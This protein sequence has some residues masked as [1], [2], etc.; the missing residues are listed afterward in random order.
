MNLHKQSLP[1]QPRWRGYLAS[2]TLV[3]AFFI[4]PF[5]M[6]QNVGKVSYEF[7]EGDTI[8]LA[9]SSININRL[10]VKNDRILSIV[11]PKGFCTSSGNQK[12][13]SGS[14]TLKINIAL[15]F[16]AHLTTEKG[17]LFA[18]FITPKSTPALVTEFVW[19][20]SYKEQKSPIALAAD[21]PAAMTA[22][23]KSMMRF[24]HDGSPIAGFKRHDVDPKTLPKDEAKLA[25]IP[26]TVFVGSDYSGVI[27]QL[28]NQGNQ[29]MVLTTAQFYSDSARSAAL[30]AY[31]L[32]PGQT[33]TLYLITGGGA[34][35]VR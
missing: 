13:A 31:H 24:V 15:P 11:C 12:D 32:A 20:E 33:T 34:A 18:L 7:N 10:V 5:A 29:E 21:Y 23:T 30:D 17:R 19:S 27:Y 25:I 14:I 2:I 1:P 28:K 8:P 26:Q 6:A 22:L 9:L 3:L 16:T 4:A 35:H